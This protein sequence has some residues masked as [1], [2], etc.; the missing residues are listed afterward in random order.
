MPSLL[1]SSVGLGDTPALA[2]IKHSRPPACRFLNGQLTFWRAMDCCE[3]EA[4][5]RTGGRPTGKQSA[6]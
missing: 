1:A 6:T 2:V 4:R 5:G 3:A